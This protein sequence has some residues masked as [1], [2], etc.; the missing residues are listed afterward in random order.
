[1]SVFSQLGQPRARWL[2]RQTQQLGKDEPGADG[3]DQRQSDA[4]AWMKLSACR[5]GYQ[6]SHKYRARKAQPLQAQDESSDGGGDDDKTREGEGADH[7]LL[8]SV[9]Y[10]A[11]YEIGRAPCR[12]RA[13]HRGA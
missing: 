3:N 12:E 10:A 5:R 13:R 7:V 11:E 9:A 8:G 6:N 2:K 1:M 4:G